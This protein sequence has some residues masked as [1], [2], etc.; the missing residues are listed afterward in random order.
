[1]N[2]LVWMMLAAGLRLDGV[3]VMDPQALADELAPQ[4]RADLSGAEREAL[5]ARVQAR[6]RAAG[7]PFARAYLPPLTDQ[8][9]AEGVA[10]RIGVV[11]GRYGRV[12]V[13]GNAARE[14]APWLDALRPGR[15][16]GDELE[17]QVQALSRLPG[18]AVGAG[19]GPGDAVG[20][21][22]VALVVDQA[23]RWALDARLD[24][25]GNRY[26]GRVRGSVAGHANG[27]LLFG[28][29]LTASAGG[30]NG[31]G[32]DGATAYQV[33]L[34]RRG[35]SVSFTAAHHHYQL[36]AEFAP[37][38]AQG[39]VDSAGL[40]STVPLTTRGPGRLIWQL[41]LEARRMRNE[42]R[43]V[44][45][46]DRR[47][48]IAMTTGLQVVAYPAAGMAAWG[49]VRAEIGELRFRDPVAARMDRQSARTAG[50]YLVLSADVALLRHWT[51]WG[52][53]LRGSGQM[54]DRNLDGSRQFA[55]GGARSVRAWPLGETSGDHG[56][57]LQAEL[58]H[59]WQ[60]LE[61]FAFLDAGRVKFHHTPWDTSARGQALP[62]GRTLAG[63]G[64]GV[65]WQHGPWSAEGAAGWRL[66]R[67]P[68]H[69]QSLTDPRAKAP[70]VWVS[71]SYSL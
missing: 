21:G 35:S 30:N 43:S 14:A 4:V 10:L 3:T 61:P 28:D 44:A 47:R 22:D 19:L 2:S 55:L 58:R 41:G 40:M 32:W 57:L 45:I 51:S 59:R 29:R 15:P 46:E 7:R 23:R 25:H 36:G 53:M 5:A 6:V 48:A 18:V 38:R 20:E 24:N 34:G 68:W 26:A 63:A 69:R 27:L 62:R 12:E 9:R 67:E 54:S 13:R 16:I 49:G 31:K 1:M 65:R 66:A 39:Q 50:Q 33:P 52:L 64:V 8:D 42:Q 37:L 60:S 70:Q 17:R 71:V 56:A 11:E